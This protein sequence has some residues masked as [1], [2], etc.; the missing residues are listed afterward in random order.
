MR[1]TYP[2]VSLLLFIALLSI[3]S[4][5]GCKNK[6]PKSPPEAGKEDFQ[7]KEKLSEYGFFKNKL[8]ALDP[9]DG[10]LSYDLNTPLFTDYAIKNRFIVLPKGCSMKYISEGMLDFPD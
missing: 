2:I 8:S 1:K 4:E 3:V 6:S 9:A 7:F 10:V 5:Q